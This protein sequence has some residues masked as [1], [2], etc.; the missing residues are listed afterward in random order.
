MLSFVNEIH[1]TY[2]GR[3][4]HI[5]V[6][7]LTIT[8]SDNG[9]S[10]GRHQAIIWTNV[11]ILVIGPIET[12]FSENLI[13]I[14]IFSFTKMRLKVSSEK[15]RLFCLGLSVLR[16]GWY[17]IVGLLALYPRNEICIAR[18]ISLYIIL[19][20]VYSDGQRVMVENT[21]LSIQRALLNLTRLTH[22]S[23]CFPNRDIE[24]AQ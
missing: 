20:F 6:S 1:L 8:G 21:H 10:L 22:R 16:S 2:W 7:R 23:N 5:Y 3:V 18:Y 12:N 17:S 13:D 14:L 11:E 4:T 15:W 9:L 24:I 19:L